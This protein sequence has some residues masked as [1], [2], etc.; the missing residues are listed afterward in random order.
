VYLFEGQQAG[1]AYS[2]KSAQRIFQLA[3]AKANIK[4]DA[5]FHS[6]RHSFAT[7]LLE[8]GLDIRHIKDLLGLFSIKT[9]ERYL[10][11][12]REQL[13]NIASP[14]DSFWE[15]GKHDTL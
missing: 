2:T 15:A 10:H 9:T 13:I 8:K 11:V 14:L 6:L 3:K 12:K 7:H 5:S 4:K 1:T